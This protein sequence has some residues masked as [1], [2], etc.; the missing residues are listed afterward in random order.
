M[1]K[2]VCGIRLLFRH[3]KPDGTFEEKDA[4]SGD[5]L[6]VPPTTGEA[7]KLVN[8][9]RKVLGIHFQQGAIVDRFSLVVE[10]AAK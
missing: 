4:Y 10:A 9:G 6:G 8:D 3:V 5:W 7:D 2:Y 1:D